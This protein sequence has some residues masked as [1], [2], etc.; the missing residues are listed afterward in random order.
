M[1]Q[2]VSRLTPLPGMPVGARAAL[3]FD[4]ND[5]VDVTL[6]LLYQ[7]LSAN[8]HSDMTPGAGDLNVQVTL[9]ETLGGD[10]YLYVRTLSG[11]V[12][13]VRADGD[14]RLDAGDTIGLTFPPH[15]LHLFGPDGRTL[16]SGDP[17]RAGIAAAIPS[18]RSWPR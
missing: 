14:S 4:V 2:R 5:K 13:V 1:G 9:K 18:R 7:D 12:L 3:R 10:S 16:I 8:G 11:A 17:A 6:G 15:R